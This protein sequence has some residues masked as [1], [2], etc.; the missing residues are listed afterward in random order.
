[1][2][3]IDDDATALLMAGRMLISDPGAWTTGDYAKTAKGN[4]TYATNLKAC[5]W[6]SVGALLCVD[7][8]AGINAA[9]ATARRH[10]EQQMKGAITVFND[11]HTHA[12]VLAAWDRAIAKASPQ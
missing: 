6:C 5:S 7:K 12:E 10:L 4:G 3:Q 8:G 11:T 9:Y 1:M 2:S